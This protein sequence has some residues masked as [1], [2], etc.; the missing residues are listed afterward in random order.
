MTRF[1]TVTELKYIY[2]G[3]QRCTSVTVD[4]V[5]FINLKK[6]IGKNVE[7]FTLTAKHTEIVGVLR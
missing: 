2:P 7:A 1:V 5:Y 4:S 6:Q 3:I